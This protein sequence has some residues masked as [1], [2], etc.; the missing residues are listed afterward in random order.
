[1]VL[2]AKDLTFS[3]PK[4]LP[5]ASTLADIG[6]V[7]D[8]SDQVFRSSDELLLLGYPHREVVSDYYEADINSFRSKLKDLINCRLNPRGYLVYGENN[9]SIRD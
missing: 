8:A 7:Y 4:R 3:E 2:R 6:I 9:L 5:N 1:M